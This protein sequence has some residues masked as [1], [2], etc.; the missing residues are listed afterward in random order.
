LRPARPTSRACLAPRRFLTLFPLLFPLDELWA[1]AP[2]LIV[3]QMGIGLAL[4]GTAAFLY[5]PFS[6]RS[7]LLMGD[8]QWSNAGNT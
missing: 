6:Q 3:D 1:L 2:F 5:L 7:S 4:A 8:R